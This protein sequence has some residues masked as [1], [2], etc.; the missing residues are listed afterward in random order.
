M[1][2]LL[3]LLSA[4][5]LIVSVSYSQGKGIKVRAKSL[6]VSQ[7][8]VQVIHI[9]ET[10]M[11]NYPANGYFYCSG[12]AI[13]FTGKINGG[14]M[15]NVTL[16]QEGNAGDQDFLIEIKDH[17]GFSDDTIKIFLETSGGGIMT[18]AVDFLDSLAANSY[19]SSNFVF[20]Y[21]GSDPSMDAMDDG[22]EY[23]NGRDGT[24]LNLKDNTIYHPIN[25]VAQTNT[26][27]IKSDSVW[28]KFSVLPKW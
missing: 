22:A 4:L 9:A 1:K 17:P 28:Y 26:F 20:G 10:P 16:T 12:N 21:T 3:V 6:D 23:N 5:L 14:A 7:G 27:F 11:P 19:I 18:L 13:W 8:S 25:G 15:N 2:K 24:L